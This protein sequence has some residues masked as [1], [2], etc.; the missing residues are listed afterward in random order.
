MQKP[1]EYRSRAHSID[2]IV[3]EY[4]DPLSGGSGS[5]YPLYCMLH[6]W[7]EVWIMEV[8]DLWIKKNALI[9]DGSI[10]FEYFHD[11]SLII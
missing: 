10:F 11:I 7:H 5:E 9:R 1:Y 2:I 6:I 4:D 3:S 8:R